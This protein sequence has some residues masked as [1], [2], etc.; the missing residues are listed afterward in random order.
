[1]NFIYR[2]SEI[3]REST[4]FEEFGVVFIYKYVY[5]YINIYIFIYI[6]LI[7]GYRPNI[8]I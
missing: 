6:L 1:M 8:R 4:K 7:L 2:E 3:E 5:V